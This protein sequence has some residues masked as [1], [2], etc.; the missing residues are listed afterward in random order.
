MEDLR[1]LADLLDLQTVDSEI[2]R[3]MH[4]RETVPALKDYRRAHEKAQRLT[5]QRGDLAD[6]LRQTELALDK[7]SGE[8]DLAEA[9]LASEQNRLY[10]GGLSARDAEY[11]RREV[12]M[13]D[14]KKGEMEDEVLELM[15]KREQ[16]QGRLAELDESATAVETEKGGFEATITAAW[17]EID[18]QLARKEAR[19]ADIVPLIADDLLDLYERLRDQKDDGVA[20][21]RLA[22]GI[23]GA[24]HLQLTPAEQLE[25][26]RREPPRCIHCSAILVP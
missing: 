6:Q 22:D 19:K 8:L 2:D 18:A 12:E 23:C 15:E 24:C 4:E 5:S 20:V 14:R 26:T 9:K 3:L 21:G 7:T 11:M 16:L 25:A 10:A 1:S 13:L 17:S